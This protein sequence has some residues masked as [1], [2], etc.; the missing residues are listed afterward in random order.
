VAWKLAVVLVLA[1]GAVYQLRFRPVPVK[2][3]L[4]QRATVQSEVLGTG[5]LD[6]RTKIT[7]GSKITGRVASLGADQNDSVSKGQLLVTLDDSDLR[8]QAEMASASLEATKAALTRA[9][10]EIG[11]T[12]AILTQA[13]LDHERS[14][15]LYLKK[16]APKEEVDKAQES[17]DIAQAGVQSSRA[18]KVEAEHQ[19]LTAERTL[20]YHQARLA[21]AKI[22]CPVDDGLVTFRYREVGDIVVPGTAIMDVISMKE[23]WV[24][25][26]VDESASEALAVGQPARIVFRSD[27]Q[28]S[29]AG[30]VARLA[31]Q[32]D[33]ETREFLVDVRVRELPKNWSVG[34]RA[35]A[36]IRTAEKAD[37]LSVPQRLI[38]WRNGKPGVFVE[39]EGKARYVEVGLGL[40]G[41]ENVEVVSGLKVG[42]AVLAPADGDTSKLTEGRAVRQ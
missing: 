14:T 13:K 4:V 7:I 8:Q 31:K 12:Q 9:D 39:D 33:R 22:V 18:A 40:K 23:L 25:V 42:Q 11:R 36:Y 28:R 2:A 20:K 1:G 35:E 38:V 30:E 17:L 32:T 41:R 5:T 37:A 26:W 19:V 16:V 27:P 10:A 15:Q 6:A 24:S 21:D 29:Y 34:Q 3:F